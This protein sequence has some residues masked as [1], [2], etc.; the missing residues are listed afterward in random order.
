[1]AQ[2]LPGSLIHGIVEHWESPQPAPADKK[3][4]SDAP[5]PSSPYHLSYSAAA[6][7]PGHDTSEVA[8]C[9]TLITPAMDA[10]TDPRAFF[11]ADGASKYRHVTAVPKQPR[12]DRRAPRVA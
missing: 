8:V 5:D 10:M 4:V 3:S 1:M 2:F 12:P 11:G 7:A 6:S 9:A